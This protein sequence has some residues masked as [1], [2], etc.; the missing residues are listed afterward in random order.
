MAAVKRNPRR[1]KETVGSSPETPGNPLL[2]A[3]NL[4]EPWYPWTL[5]G[6][7]LAVMGYLALRYHTVGGMGVETDFYAELCPPAKDLLEGRFSPLNYSAKGPVYSILLDRKS[8][9]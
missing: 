9:V 2:R 8:V 7:L 5:A 3:W 4:I 6:I 1:T